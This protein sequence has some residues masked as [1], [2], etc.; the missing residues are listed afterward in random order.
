MQ[1]E[2]DKLSDVCFGTILYH[3]QPHAKKI[4]QCVPDEFL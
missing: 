3:Y 4:N 2:G 1:F